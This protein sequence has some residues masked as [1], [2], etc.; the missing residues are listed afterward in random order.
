MSQPPARP[1]QGSPLR[2]RLR[3]FNPPNPG[4][5][6]PPTPVPVPVSPPVIATTTAP[7]PAQRWWRRIRGWRPADPIK[8]AVVVAT[9]VFALAGIGSPLL[10]LTVFADTGSLARYSGYHDVLAGVQ[11]HTDGL[12]DQVDAEMPNSILFGQALRGGEFAAWNPYAVG[13]SPLGGTPN[14]AVAS[15][16]SSPYWVMPGWLAPAYIK[17]LELICAIGGTYLF[18]RRLRLRPAAATLGG[19]VFA[20]SA[21]MVVW[22]GWPQTRVAALIPVLFWAL[23]RIC[24]RVRI[25]EIALLS[26]VVAAMLLG[27]FPAV[28]GYALLTAAAYLLVRVAAQHRHRWRPVAARL[29]GAGAGVA[30]GVALAAWQLL[31]WMH[32]MASVLV[33]QR[34]Q[35][36]TDNVPGVALLTMIAPEALGTANPSD[37]PTWFGPL[38]TVD[39][40]SYVGAAA[41]VLIVTSVALAGRSRRLMPAGVWWFA[42]GAAAFWGA[43]IYYGG[44]LLLDLQGLSYLFSDNPI[45]RA[46]S[47]LG[48]LLAILAAVGFEALLAGRTIALRWPTARRLGGIAAWAGLFGAAVGFYGATRA[49]LRVHGHGDRLTFLSGQFAIGVGLVV[50]AGACVAWLWFGHP[51]LRAPWART[52]AA[53]V[54][55]V[56]V[57]GQALWWVRDYYPR[58]DRT[59]FYP[60][61]PTQA[62]LADHLGHQRFYGVDGSV[63]GSVDTM[64]GLRGFNGHSFIDQGYAE[65]AQALPGDQFPN[66]PTTTITSQAT[67]AATTAVSPVLDRAAVSYFVTPPDV[68]PF[69]TVH[70]EDTDGSILTLSPGYTYTV[71]MPV[72]GPIRAVGLVPAMSGGRAASVAVTVFDPAGKVVATGARSLDELDSG[73][74]WLVPVA[75]DD[76]APTTQLSARI[77][78]TGDSTVDVS[79]AASGLPLLSM[80]AS[81]GDNLRLVYAAE[82]VIYQRLDAMDRARWASS[83]VVETSSTGQV[84]L[85]AG[86]TL[87]ADQV[88]LDAPGPGADGQPATVSWVTDGLD[89]MVLGVTAAGSGYLVLADAI[90]TGWRVTVDGLAAPLL[91]ADHAF[92]AVALGPGTH[93]VRFFY[94]GPLTGTGAWISG[95]TAIGL[96]VAVGAEAAIGRRRARIRP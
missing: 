29:A 14:L 41:L 10:G 48:F 85:L 68:V 8:L 31:P 2:L 11:V 40:Q 73:H 64:V 74:P 54:L 65:L 36:P 49:Y 3:R 86:D 69:G 87:Q 47:V 39:A 37:Q 9:A 84:S 46:R 50:V 63:Y 94:P 53:V 24:E 18:L 75:A 58:T 71:T 32:Y 92:A 4:R 72:A 43:A 59:D 35:K 66:A 56:L 51:R 38:A 15:P 57:A 19:L 44:R 67:D 52:T 96:L 60:T 89:E 91:A 6:R 62:Y 28:T 20:S 5:F 61:N 27:G 34:A 1:R 78:I 45:G 16:L 55:I 22:T 80:V 70:T 82:S 90:Q 23:E 12:R 88:V 26:L 17:L 30:A 42:V 7:E 81:P 33:D 21:F 83:A 77:T 25:R 76:V 13:G 79:G 95:L 93:T